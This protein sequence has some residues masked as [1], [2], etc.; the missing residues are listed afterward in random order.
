METTTRIHGLDAV[1][2][3]ALLLG[4][5][6]HATMSFLPGPSLWPVPAGAP[7]LTPPTPLVTA[8]RT[9]PLLLLALPGALAAQSPAPPQPLPLDTV[10]ARYTAALGPAQALQTRRTTMRVS[11]LAPFEIPVVIEAMRPNRIRKE[12]TIQ[13][14]AQI[15]AYDGADAWRIDP[16]VPGGRRPMD[17]PTAELA[18]LLDEAD[19]DGV[20]FDAAAKGHR[21]R[22]AAPGVI[23]IDGRRVPVHTVTLT[24]RDGRSSVIHLDARSFLEVQRVD[25]RPGASRSIEI[26]ITPSDYRT[27]QGIAIPHAIEIAPQGLPTPIRVVIDHVELDVP[28]DTKRFSR[29]ARRWDASALRG[30]NHVSFP[31]IASVWMRDRCGEKRHR[32]FASHRASVGLRDGWM[33]HAPGGARRALDRADGHGPGG[34]RPP[35]QGFAGEARQAAGAAQERGG[36]ARELGLSAG[37]AGADAFA[38]ARGG[39]WSPGRCGAASRAKPAARDHAQRAAYPE[40]TAAAQGT[41]SHTN[42]SASGRDGDPPP[43]ARVPCRRSRIPEPPRPGAFPGSCGGLRS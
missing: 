15:T 22:Y 35:V 29:N 2:G 1:R 33:V 40:F 38:L 28:L 42:A 30:Y 39:P 13:G 4:V 18:D 5:M 19:F 36:R 31:P 43:A 26:T 24:R 8:M 32:R 9:L 23:T 17:V 3:G 27:V 16:F 20:L 41:D 7:S 10:L 14:G 12:V 25:T 34:V 11:G 6:L 37:G 21:T